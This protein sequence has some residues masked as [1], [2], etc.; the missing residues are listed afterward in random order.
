LKVAST[1]N[2][3]SVENAVVKVGSGTA[4]S[5]FFSTFC[6]TFCGCGGFDAH[7]NL[8][9]SSMELSVLDSLFGSCVGAGLLA[10]AAGPFFSA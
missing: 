2:Q 1:F 7:R 3:A 6:H 8:F 5:S 9:S 10:A 4:A